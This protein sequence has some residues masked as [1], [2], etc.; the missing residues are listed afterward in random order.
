MSSTSLKEHRAARGDAV[1]E[2]RDVTRSFGHVQALRGASLA[3]GPGEIVGLVGD[4][5]AGKSTLIKVLA[6]AIQPDSGEVRV[7]GRPVH[8]TQPGESRALGIE[9]VYQDLALAP[10]LDA[11]ENLF[12][13]REHLADGLAGR[14]GVLRRRRMRAEGPK[15]LE[16]MRVALPSLDVPVAML[17]G[18]QRQMIA[19]VRALTFAQRVVLLDEPTAALSVLQTEHVVEL[20]RTASQEK[21]IGVVLI[22]HNL[23]ELITIVDRVEVMRLGRGVASL[24]AAE[25]TGQ[26]LLAA[27][28]GL[29]TQQPQ[30]AS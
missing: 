19:V 3:V 22:S 15:L 13:G 14:L 20:I 9:V 24:T 23:P 2:A 8:M 26:A 27:M 6:G 17:S 7:D 10:D 25:A 16:R 1:I 18:G 5:G 29:S 28:S 11:I 30:P 4:N 21:Q 12:L